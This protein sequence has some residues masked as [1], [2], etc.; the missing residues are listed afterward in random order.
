MFSPSLSALYFSSE[1]E[2]LLEMRG[3]KIQLHIFWILLKKMEHFGN[4]WD[5]SEDPK[6]PRVLCPANP[7]A[8]LPLLIT[9]TE[10]MAV[11]WE[12]IWGCTDPPEGTPACPMA[13]GCPQTS[14]H[15]AKL[16]GFPTSS[17]EDLTQ[18]N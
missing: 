6:A 10:A 9:Y 12:F 8:M 4:S 17:A 7:C 11:V 14:R 15:D 1:K 3:K 2:E 16:N 5:Y 13:Q 18:L